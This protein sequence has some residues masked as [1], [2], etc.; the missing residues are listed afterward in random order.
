MGRHYSG[1]IEGKFAFGIQ[2]SLSPQ[3][4]G[5][6]AT[7]TTASFYFDEDNFDEIKKEIKK[8]KKQLGEKLK[9]LND[10]FK[11]NDCFNDDELKEKFGLDQKDLENYFDLELGEKILKCVKETGQCAFDAEIE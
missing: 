8:I 7:Y 11:K 4:F 2:D 3:R 1:D 6:D 10:Y 5:V 9:L